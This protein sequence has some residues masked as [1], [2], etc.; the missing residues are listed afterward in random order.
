[1]SS[2]RFKKLKANLF[3]RP[4]EKRETDRKSGPLNVISLYFLWLCLPDKL[5]CDFMKGHLF[6]DDLFLKLT[7]V[8]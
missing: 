8:I 1:M 5:H 7:V 3:L 6:V 2:T 4:L